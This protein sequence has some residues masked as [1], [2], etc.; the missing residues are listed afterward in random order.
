MLRTYSF[1]AAL[2]LK[3]TVLSFAFLLSCSLAASAVTETIPHSFNRTP[4]GAHSEA[5]L[6]ADVAGNLYGTTT[7]GGSYGVVFKLTRNSHGLWTQTILHNF[8]G[9][10]NGPDGVSPSGGLLFDGAGNLYGTTGGGGSSECGIAYEL[11][12]TASG[13]WKET[14]LHNFACYPND[15]TRPSGGLI[16]DVAG[17][18]YGVTSEGGN[19][20]CNDDQGDP[21]FGCG[22]V[23]ELSP[24]AG[25]TYNETILYN[26]PEGG[27][28]ESYPQGNLA[29][30]QSGNLYG[31]ASSGGSGVCSFYGGCGTVFE[32]AHGSS[33][34][35]ESTI[36][37]F[38]GTSDGDTPVSGVV[39]DSAGNLYVT[40]AGYYNYPAVIELTPASGGTWTETSL[41]TF[42]SNY[43]QVYAAVVMDA[44]G[45]L[46]GTTVGGGSTT[47]CNTSGCG[48]I[49]KLSKGSSGWTETTLYDFAGG[50]DGGAP[51]S[52]LL[53][54]ST[55]DLYTTTA[56]YGNG[57]GS[58]FKLA[59][60]S[61]GSWKGTAL[62]D[63][64]VLIEGTHPY[65]SL[66]ADGQGNYYGT[67]SQGGL[68]V[69]CGY[70][71][72]CGTVYK[73]SPSGSGWKET[74]LYSFT[75]T[76]GDG[77][78]PAGNLALDAAGNLYGTTEYGGNVVTCNGGLD[79]CG[80]VYKLSPNGEGIWT[81]TVLYR[82][83]GYTTGDGSNPSAGLAI[84]AS[85]NLYGTTPTGGQYGSGTAFVLKP[86]SGGTYT[87]TL[88]RTFG[89]PGD[90][91][92]PSS[93]LI[94][95]KSGNLYGTA[96]YYNNI[97][98]GV[99]YR[100]FPSGS[101][102]TES[103]L[104]QFSTAAEGYAPA[105]GVIFDAEGNLYGTTYS[106]GTYNVGLAYKL[107]PTS[108]GFWSESVLYNF[109][110]VDGDG[111]E[112]QQGLAFDS[113]GNLYGTTTYGGVYSN[114]CTTIGCGVVFEL[115]PTSKGPW[116]ER[117]LH[118]FTTGND[119]SN[120]DAPVVVDPRGNVFGT[121]FNGG[122]GASG[123]VFEIKP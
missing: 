49:Y 80:T 35:T 62:Y 60:A 59:P 104:Y 15:G 29:F 109:I 120:P 27:N 79:Q 71:L 6:I 23:Y 111:A 58:I 34:W 77:A 103:V 66:L 24:A 119:G 112:P 20:G 65:S 21:P 38:Q 61:G 17:N 117:V 97:N 37:N 30:D 26:F 2:S 57:V 122:T 64:P 121:A 40:S 31:T 93:G 68:N 84:D 89:A 110:G 85:G 47:A 108:S 42:P 106:G 10:Y 48:S 69:D 46:Y 51:Y 100:L 76:G 113:A 43:D 33:G 11:S 13:P 7:Q 73:L 94:F 45:N 116:H 82:F 81:E 3:A 14:I 36:Y 32:L 54:D 95:D 98:A 44:A 74:V 67:T 16:F 118:R 50:A 86:S 55:G 70:Y 28:F 101:S 102:W 52:T 123:I 107:T 8:S 96:G 18:L 41:Y 78:Y 83:N 12:P 39:F 25:G 105:G 91:A 1:K 4:N 99:V 9:G 5:G 114:S 56:N 53:R 22:T 87:E 75:G 19:G 63:F 88:L 72:G 115:T 90:V 92:N